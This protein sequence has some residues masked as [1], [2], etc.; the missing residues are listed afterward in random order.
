MTE[1]LCRTS[2]YDVAKQMDCVE[3]FFTSSV[4]SGHLW[5]LGKLE[6]LL[7]FC[8]EACLPIEIRLYFSSCNCEEKERKE[9]CLRLVFS[10]ERRE[11]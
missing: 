10:Y 2:L 6:M 3:G 9:I 8:Q 1:Q 11:N 7:F 5:L 4:N